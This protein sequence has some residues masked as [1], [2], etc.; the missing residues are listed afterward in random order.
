MNNIK[1]IIELVRQYEVYIR[2]PKID[3]EL[4]QEIKDIL[5]G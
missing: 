2:N 4:E 1:R 5:I 3:K